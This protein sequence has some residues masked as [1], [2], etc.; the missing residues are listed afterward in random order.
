MQTSLKLCSYLTL[1]FTA[2]QWVLVNSK[3][4]IFRIM[5]VYYTH[6]L[7]I[8]SSY[9]LFFVNVLMVHKWNVHFKSYYQIS[10]IA[11]PL[12]SIISYV[13]IGL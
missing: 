4:S 13:I 6:N 5:E 1:M 12:I 9:F 11:C 2:V 8:L 7:I 3:L 10:F